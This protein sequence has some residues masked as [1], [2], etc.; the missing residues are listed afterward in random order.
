METKGLLNGIPV[1]DLQLTQD[2]DV[3]EY[4]YIGSNSAHKVSS[5][6]FIVDVLKRK[7]IEEFNLV[8]YKESVAARC[9]SRWHRDAMPSSAGV[10]DIDFIELRGGKPVALIEATMSNSEE[11]E[12]GLFSFLSRG[13]AQASIYLQ[14]KELF[15]T[16]AYV[17]TYT[18]EMQEVEILKLDKAMLGPIDKFDRMR[19][20]FANAYLER[21]EAEDNTQAQGMAV[22]ALYES[23][24]QD[25]VDSL[26]KLRRRCKIDRYLYWL[27]RKVPLPSGNGE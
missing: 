22:S 19:Q 17:V 25:F 10:M 3:F 20:Q 12:Y 6:E 1:V 11:L 2:L 7:P 18:K 14:L 4:Q 24:G 26:I 9:Y 15:S 16:D 23:G 27:N 21:K 13:F 8:K 5:I